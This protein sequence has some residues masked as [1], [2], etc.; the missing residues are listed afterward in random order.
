VPGVAVMSVF[1]VHVAPT[2]AHG[3]PSTE[4]YTLKP[5]DLSSSHHLQLILTDSILTLGG[6]PLVV[7]NVTEE[8]VASISTPENPRV[9]SYVVTN[10]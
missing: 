5:V 10:V 1:G 8:P 6:V 7:R 4:P 2:S 9:V 3:A